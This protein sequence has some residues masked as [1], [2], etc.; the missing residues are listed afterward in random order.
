MSYTTEI[1][2]RN[3]D[4]QTRSARPVGGLVKRTFDIAFSLVA[5]LILLPLLAG[6]C[7]VVLATSP[8]PVL[9]R[10]RRIGHG[11]RSFNCLKFRTMEINSERRLQDYLAASEEARREWE[12]FRK[13]QNDPRVTPFG[14][15]MRRSSLDELPQLFNVLIGDM[16]IVGPRPIIT[17][18]VEKYQEHFGTYASGRPGL[19]GLW[20]VKGR[21]TTTY[22]QRVAYDVE[23]LRNWS[24]LRD[25]WIILTTIAEVSTG[26]G[27]Y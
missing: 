1:V 11:G 16:S 12:V 24:L 27:A 21:N 9:F 22:D 2:S 26:R 5:I 18:E 8:G 3:A 4:L 25:A 7:L 15:F 23:Y 20:Q 14:A 19:T 10:H 17:D 6:C 13:L